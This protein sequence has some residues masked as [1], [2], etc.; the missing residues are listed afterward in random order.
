MD[1]AMTQ[2]YRDLDL[3]LERLRG[4]QADYDWARS[5]GDAERAA[6]VRIKLQSITAEH[7]RLMRRAINSSAAAR[8]A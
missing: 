3:V 7:D 1:V 6:L 5:R 2:I 4:A 8:V